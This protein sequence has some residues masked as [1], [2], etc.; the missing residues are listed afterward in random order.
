MT[1]CRRPSRSSCDAVP[2]LVRIAHTLPLPCARATTS[3]SPYSM[4]VRNSSS[5]AASPF[6]LGCAHSVS[7]SGRCGSFSAPWSCRRASMALT[8]LNRY[9]VARASRISCLIALGRLDVARESV[10]LGQGEVVGLLDQ[11]AAQLQG[12]GLVIVDRM[13]VGQHHDLLG[14]DAAGRLGIPLRARQRLEIA[15]EVEVAQ[16]GAVLVQRLGGGVLGI[17]EQQFRLLVAD[18]AVAALLLALLR[19]HQRRSG[20]ADH[21]ACCRSEPG[22][23]R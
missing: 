15:V 10:R 1:D 2:A 4:V 9:G 7:M 13:V 3:G 18:Q 12:A 6:I 17:A 22:T 8:R 16:S 5:C 21:T 14:L 20:R 11:L 23:G 19:R